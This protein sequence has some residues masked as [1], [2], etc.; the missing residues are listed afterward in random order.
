MSVALL[1]GWSS[2]LIVVMAEAA[3]KAK[4]TRR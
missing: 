3:P 1:C 2:V 4:L